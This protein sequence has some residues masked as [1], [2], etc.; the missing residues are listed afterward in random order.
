MEGITYSIVKEFTCS[1]S[2][3]ECIIVKDLESQ[4]EICFLKNEWEND[5]DEDTSGD[6]DYNPENLPEWE[7]GYL[8]V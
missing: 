8:F 1:M 4:E 7:K 6:P 2:G 5:E 3:D